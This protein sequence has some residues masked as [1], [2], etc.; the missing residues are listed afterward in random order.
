MVEANSF[1]FFI[2]IKSF[3]EP[4]C[5]RN[6]DSECRIVADVAG[7]ALF[8]QIQLVLRLPRHRRIDHNLGNTG[9][10]RIHKSGNGQICYW[11][12]PQIHNSLKLF[13]TELNQ[14]H[15]HA[16]YHFRKCL[17]KCIPFPSSESKTY[18]QCWCWFNIQHTKI[19]TKCRQRHNGNR[20]FFI[21]II[22]YWWPNKIFKISVW[23]LAGFDIAHNVKVFLPWRK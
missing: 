6:P 9:N 18:Q 8:T 19:L 10:V 12:I 4:F 13:L 11:K 22:S 15:S 17:R 7:L 5:P 16:F 20:G 3:D 14:C 2:H 1:L 23:V 21:A